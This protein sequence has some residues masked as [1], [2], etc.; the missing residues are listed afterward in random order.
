MYNKKA[1]IGLSIN[2]IVVIIISLVIL[3]G[4]IAFLNK[5]IGGAEDIKLKMDL[6]TDQQLEYLLV[7]QGK[8]VALPL[9]RATVERGDNHVFGIGILNID[10]EVNSFSIE[11]SLSKLLDSGG[12]ETALS[13]SEKFAIIEESVLFNTEPLIIEE[14]EHHKEAILVTIPTNKPSGTYIFNAKVIDQNG[15]QYGNTQKFYVEA[16]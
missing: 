16:K 9:H 3:G 10:P 4:G 1:A 2:T 8:Q 14:S 7:D 6:K 15:E 5:L 11:V 12:K 13:N